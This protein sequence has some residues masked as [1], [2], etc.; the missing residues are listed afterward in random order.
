MSHQQ[1]ER[2]TKI[3]CTMG[4]ACLGEVLPRLVEAGMNVARLNF[5]HGSQEEHGEWIQRLRHLSQSRGTPL[6][7]LQDLAGSRSASA[8]SRAGRWNS[9][10]GKPS[11]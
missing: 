6:A 1:E 5:S 3:V 2:R 7:I 10:R 8:N 9:M 4:P 11:I